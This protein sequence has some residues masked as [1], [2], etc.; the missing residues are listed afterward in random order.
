[1]LLGHDVCAGIE[2]LIKTGGIIL[3]VDYD[4][5]LNKEAKEEAA[6]TSSFLLT[7]CEHNVSGHLISSHHA[8]PSCL[9]KL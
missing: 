1:V 8:F 3:S 2:T 4:P 5:T 7:D 6:D 9:L